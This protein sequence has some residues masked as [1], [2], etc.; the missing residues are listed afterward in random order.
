MKLADLLNDFALATRTQLVVLTKAGIERL[1]SPKD[2]CPTFSDRA[3]A[4]CLEQLTKSHDRVIDCGGG[5]EAISI[6]PE[7]PGLMQVIICRRGDGAKADLGVLS[8][9]LRLQ[10]VPY[11]ELGVAAPD[12]NPLNT[13]LRLELAALTGLREM[14]NRLGAA[15]DP[16]TFFGDLVAY[17]GELY[18][19]DAAVA[20]WRRPD[21]DLGARAEGVKLPG[22]RGLEEAFDKLG[23]LP[24]RHTPIKPMQNKH[25]LRFEASFDLKP[26]S[27]VGMAFGE[28]PFPYHV[29]LVWKRPEAAAEFLE[30]L[31]TI[32]GQLAVF[33]ER[34]ARHSTV[35]SSYLATVRTMVNALEARD[36]YHRGHSDRVMR[37]AVR[38]GRARG[39][40]HEELT[41]LSFA[42]VLHDIG[43][44]GL[45]EEII[46]KDTPLDE[47]EW[48]VVRRHP[49][50]GE[51]LVGG[52][53]YL[54]EAARTIRHHH[55]R[56]DGEGYPNRL[57]GEEIPL[58]ARILAI[59]ESYDA[60]TSE[61]P[62]RHPLTTERAL[63]ELEGNAGE[64][65]DP[66]LV[67]LFI[68]NRC[69]EEP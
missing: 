18:D 36:P 37:Y 4:P 51:A 12:K 17:L 22:R 31:E 56:W 15:L 38:L 30:R 29:F 45:A 54:E 64:Q 5:S 63:L 6:H 52:V 48:V 23:K 53:P 58:P 11:A 60:M 49:I 68:E 47:A 55:E 2:H 40:G 1:G 7:V 35:D 21:G 13:N 44:V 69:Y 66:E 8:R 26:D 34:L 42:A 16:E 14:E 65:F 62:Y 25:F 3:D 10:L 39:L 32:H 9:L 50:V 46:G 33:V 27:G 24:T 61:R 41:S 19:T 67:P 20:L 59:A 28:V 43:K 57:A